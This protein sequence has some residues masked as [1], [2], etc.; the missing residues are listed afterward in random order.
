MWTT[1]Y[2]LE[3]WFNTWSDTLVDLSFARKKRFD[4]DDDKDVEGSLA[5]YPGML[6]RIGD[7]DETDGS[8]D[9]TT[10]QRGGPPLMT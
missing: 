10:G 1:S 9:D 5:F 8:L 7:I 6:D 4:N 2:S 3:V